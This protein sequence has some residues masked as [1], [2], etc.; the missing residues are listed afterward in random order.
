MSKFQ[1]SFESD[2]NYSTDEIISLQEDFAS[3]IEDF[4]DEVDSKSIRVTNGDNVVIKS[5]VLDSDRE[6]EIAFDVI[7]KLSWREAFNF[8]MDAKGDD[9]F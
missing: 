8:V 9:R 5:D 4:D 6:R 3:F 7:K 1:I 2:A